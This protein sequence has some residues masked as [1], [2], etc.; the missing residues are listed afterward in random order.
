MW[1][2]I[3][4]MLGNLVGGITFVG[5]TLCGT[6]AHTAPSRRVSHPAVAPAVPDQVAV[7]GRVMTGMS[8]PAL[9]AEPGQPVVAC[10]QP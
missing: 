4:A 1:N 2:E 3:P 5:L 6:Y 9:Q 10:Q 7:C 8:W